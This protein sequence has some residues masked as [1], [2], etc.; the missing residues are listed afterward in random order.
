MAT[1]K[2]ALIRYKVLDNCFRNPGK[3][4]TVKDL[5][6]ECNILLSEIDPRSGGISRRQIY[7]DIAFMGSSEGWGVEFDKKREGR[8]M[9][10]R[11]ADLNFSINNMPLNEMEINQIRSAMGILSQFE[12]M[13]QFEWVHEILT[14]LQHGIEIEKEPLEIISFDNNLYLRGIEYLGRLYNAIYYKKV[15]LISYQPFTSSTPT[16]L[17]IHPYYLKQYNN[18]WFLF[19]Y[20]PAIGKSDWT[21]AL[22]RILSIKELEGI[23]EP[24]TTIDWK[25]YFED[26]IGVTKP[27]GSQVE[28]IKLHFYGLT[29]KYVE[30]KPIH[31]SQKSKWIDENI[32]EVR[33]KLIINTEFIQLILSHGE[34]AKMLI[35]VDLC[36]K[37]TKRLKNALEHYQGIK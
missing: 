25:D 13:P 33:L 1:N 29:G 12:G 5:I 36:K 18:R 24:N 9:I 17:I 30:S 10:Y 3:N 11:Y 31:G 4:Y 20:N 34:D 16:D 14:K 27:E 21:M 8:N 35:P 32:L 28:D 26:I 7:D 37:I 19:G 23:Y 22:D 15:L 6:A 2:N